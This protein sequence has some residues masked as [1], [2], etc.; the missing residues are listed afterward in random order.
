MFNDEFEDAVGFGWLANK[1]EHDWKTLIANKTKEVERL[2][3]IY[4]SLLTNAG[5]AYYEGKGVITDPHTVEVQ[6]VCLAGGLMVYVQ[7]HSTASAINV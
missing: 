3:S 7:R 2:N 6:Q 1:P 4:G 5:V